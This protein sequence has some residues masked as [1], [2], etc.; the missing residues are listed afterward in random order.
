MYLANLLPHKFLIY[1]FLGRGY[2]PL[3][4]E[5]FDMQITIHSKQN[6][7]YRGYKAVLCNA[8]GFFC[9]RGFQKV[10]VNGQVA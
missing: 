1:T 6:A 8:L 7:Q 4:K 3:A 5:L 10:A 2:E 9:P